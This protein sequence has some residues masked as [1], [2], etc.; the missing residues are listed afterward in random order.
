MVLLEFLTIGKC[1]RFEVFM[2]V[3]MMMIFFRVLAPRTLNERK[4]FP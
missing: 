4:S 3:M 2:V 1:V